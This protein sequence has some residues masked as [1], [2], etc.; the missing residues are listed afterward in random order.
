MVMFSC[1]MEN[2]NKLKLFL[3]KFSNKKKSKSCFDKNI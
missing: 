3:G 1:F 2:F